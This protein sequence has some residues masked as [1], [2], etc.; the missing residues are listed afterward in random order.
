[1]PIILLNTALSGGRVH[2]RET[3]KRGAHANPEP[4]VSLLGAHLNTLW[5]WSSW[6]DQ[7]LACWDLEFRPMQLPGQRAVMDA[8]GW[9]YAPDLTLS[10]M[11][12]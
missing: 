7:D 12:T 4:C 5:E 6:R 8:R 9:G 2:G 11:K 1:M 10:H 3:G